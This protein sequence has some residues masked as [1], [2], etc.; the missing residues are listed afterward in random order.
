MLLVCAVID[1]KNMQV[2]KPLLPMYI[3]AI[4]ALIGM[5]LGWNCAYPINPGKDI[6]ARFFTAIAGWSFEVFT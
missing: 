5:S 6:A 1:E 4:V 2:S 3:G